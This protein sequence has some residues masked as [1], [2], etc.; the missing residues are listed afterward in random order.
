MKYTLKTFNKQFPD[1]DSCLQTIFEI[2]KPDD[3]PC[4]GI[5]SDFKRVTTLSKIKRVQRKSYYCTGCSFQYYPLVGTVFQKTRTPLKDWFTA[6]FLMTTTRNGLAAKEIQR[7]MGVTYK[8]AWRMAKKLREHMSKGLLKPEEHLF[9]G[10]VEMDETYV[11]GLKKNKHKSKLKNDHGSGKKVP[12]L[13]IIERASGEVYVKVVRMV[14]AKGIADTLRDTVDLDAVVI[15]DGA[16]MYKNIDQYREVINHSKD[17]YVRGDWHTN[18]IEGFWS[19]MKRMI[20]GTHIHVSRKHLQLYANEAAWR[21]NN[22]NNAMM[23]QLIRQIA[24]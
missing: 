7:I 17:E 15:T 6:M 23:D 3:C 14:S 4:C 13:G 2:R 22:R 16:S 8:C 1:D 24:A 11:G 21:Y 12:V 20:K 9:E 10:A 18:T 5:K 19:H